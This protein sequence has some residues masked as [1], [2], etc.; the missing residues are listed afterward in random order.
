MK[1]A[2]NCIFPF[3]FILFAQSFGQNNSLDV[4]VE[5]NKKIEALNKKISELE[6]KIEFLEKSSNDFETVERMNRRKF[7]ELEQMLVQLQTHVKEFQSIRNPNSQSTS[8]IKY[9]NKNKN[10]SNWRKLKLNM[11]SIQVLNLLGQPLK[12]DASGPYYIYWIYSMNEYGFK[13][14]FVSLKNS[15]VKS[16][17][18]PDF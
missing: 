15:Q 8:N 12:V 2:K 10:I 11:S 9:M 4:D 5:Q 14:S 13:E 1:I 17:K 16:W 18:E 6:S 7:A 3:V